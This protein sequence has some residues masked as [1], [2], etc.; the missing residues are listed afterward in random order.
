[1]KPVKLEKM[2]LINHV[3]R[4]MMRRVS[5]SF[6]LDEKVKEK[7]EHLYYE[8]RKRK[9]PKSYSQIVNEAIDLYYNKIL[10]VN[11]GK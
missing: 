6:S 5:R 11:V 7:L 8:S 1:M 9:D 3:E 2:P 4:N 10:G